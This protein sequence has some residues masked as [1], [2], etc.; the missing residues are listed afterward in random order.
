MLDKKNIRKWPES[1][2]GDLEQCKEH[3]KEKLSIFCEDHSQLICH[4]CHV[5]DQ[6]KVAL[7]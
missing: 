4:V 2:V 7:V 1:N 3:K 6:I 5:H